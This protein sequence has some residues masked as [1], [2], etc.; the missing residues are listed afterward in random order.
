M[1]EEYS[2]YIDSAL[3]SVVFEKSNGDFHAYIPG[4]Y[5]LEATASSEDDC[6]TLLRTKLG[7]WIKNRRQDGLTVPVVGGFRIAT[8]QLE[9]QEEKRD[10]LLQLEHQI[11]LLKM[12]LGFGSDGRRLTVG[13][14]ERFN[15]WYKSYWQFIVSIASVS[16]IAIAYIGYGV[17]PI[18]SYRE[19]GDKIRMS[20]R[21]NEIGD[22]LLLESGSTSP[23]AEKAYTAALELYPSNLSA[24]AGLLKAQILD[25]EPGRSEY[26]NGIAQAKLS[27]ARV[28]LG[29]DYYLLYV[30]GIID[31]HQAFAATG[32]DQKLL[33]E[34]ARK[35]FEKSTKLQPE[36]SGNYLGLGLYHLFFHGPLTA[37]SV[38]KEACDTNHRSPGILTYMGSLKA[39]RR[40]F[41]E[42]RK[43]LEAANTLRT[44]LET[45]IVLGDVFRHL[46][47]RKKN[48]L[49]AAIIRHQNALAMANRTNLV[50][51]VDYDEFLYSDMPKDFCELSDDVGSQSFDTLDSYKVLSYYSLSLDYLLANKK[52]EADKAFNLG[53]SLD[54]C[55]TSSRKEYY[56][57]YVNQAYCLIVEYPNISEDAKTSLK[58]NMK[59]F[60]SCE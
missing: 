12:N 48:Y 8:L 6:K 7:N 24:R 20:R 29:E 50:R 23:D 34:S 35:A 40:N 51:G 2:H 19:T 60:E 46:S 39:S 36:F 13:A 59:R 15:R 38:F 5:G 31:L 22:K 47:A 37:L 41:D 43:D 33:L 25:V 52:A 42:A 45:L 3:E 16:V 30:E 58:A 55:V 28:Y 10:R 1:Q 4:F 21:Y 11:Q 17:D 54:R 18:Q 26:D 53:F 27:A 32:S 9:V 57:W 56:G 14:F 49:D 44:R